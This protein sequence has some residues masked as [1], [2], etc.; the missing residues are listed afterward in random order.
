MKPR[1]MHDGVAFAREGK[2]VTGRPV[3]VEQS[4]RERVKRPQNGRGTH[5]HRDQQARVGGQKNG[6][7]QDHM[8]EENISTCKLDI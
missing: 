1:R 6:R 3:T 7:Y 5:R 4:E 2:T 8:T